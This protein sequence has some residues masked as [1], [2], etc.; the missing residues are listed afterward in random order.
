MTA[1]KKICPHCGKRTMVRKMHLNGRYS[2]V[3]HV[4]GIQR[5][6]FK[7]DIKKDVV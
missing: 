5:G 2:L 1:K 3:C 6:E 4:C 7:K